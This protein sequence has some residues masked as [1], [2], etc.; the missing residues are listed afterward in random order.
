VRSI[1]DYRAAAR[2]A[3]KRY[4]INPDLFE[5]QIGVE[6]GFRPG[7]SSPAGAQGIAQFM[8]ATAKG[9]GVNLHDNRVSD[10]LD[11]AAR[12]M[13]QNL[14]K[15]G[16]WR[17]ALVAYNAG[18]GRVG[19]PLYPE[20]SA[21]VSRILQ[22]FSAGHEANTG[23]P[24]Q[25]QTTTTTPGVDNSGV[26]AQLIS[27]FLGRSN[28]NPVDFAMGIR[29]AQDVPGHTVTST[30]PGAAPATAGTGATGHGGSKLLEL[31]WQGPGG[32]DIKDGKKVPQG[33]VSGHR[34]HVHVAAG[35]KTVVALGEL[36]QKMG[37]HVGENPNFGGVNPVHVANS[38][39][40]RDQAIDVSGTP[41]Q[42]RAY[43]HRVASM[44][45]I[46]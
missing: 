38:F 37:L 27:N 45:G 14:K 40:Y 35:P 44:H 28:Q 12:L 34:D 9:M 23:T 21:Y 43:A 32:I 20:T 42:M 24:Q 31:F 11:G 26:R 2:R 1:P 17:D 46:R 13:A 15:F 10:D 4:G 36:A 39:H 8:P 33:F 29:A 3:A 18:A 22:G 5:R 30:T 41:A 7:A 25:Q 6:S 16:N 19:K